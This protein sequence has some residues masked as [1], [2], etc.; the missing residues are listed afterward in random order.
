MENKKLTMDDEIAMHEIIAN[1]VSVNEQENLCATLEA[2]YNSVEESMEQNLLRVQFD[3]V[4]ENFEEQDVFAAQLDTAEDIS[5]RCSESIVK[6][7][8]K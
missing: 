5:K 4:D 7:E 3:G 2:K 6:F 8:D 1:Q